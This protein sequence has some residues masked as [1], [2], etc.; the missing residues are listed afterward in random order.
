MNDL[1]PTQN[2]FDLSVTMSSREIADLCE[3]R[4]DHVMID[5]EKM[6]EEIGGLK[7]EASSY[8]AEYITPQNKT[9]KEYRLPK[10]LTGTQITG[11]ALKAW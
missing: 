11:R 10:D 3:K 1:A 4:L 8:E 2:G 6:L 5:I 7:N 9:A